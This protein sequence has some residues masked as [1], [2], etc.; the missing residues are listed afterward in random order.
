MAYAY[1]YADALSCDNQPKFS[2]MDNTAALWF[3]V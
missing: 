1:I 3:K 2:Q